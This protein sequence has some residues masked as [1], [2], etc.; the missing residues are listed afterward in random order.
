[1]PTG[2]EAGWAQCGFGRY[3]EDKILS[4][5]PESNVDFSVIQT[6]HNHYT[7]LVNRGGELNTGTVRALMHFGTTETN[8]PSKEPRTHTS[9]APKCVS[10]PCPMASLPLGS[11]HPGSVD[12]HSF[13]T[14][15]VSCTRDST[16]ADCIAEPRSGGMGCMEGAEGVTPSMYYS[17]LLAIL[18]HIS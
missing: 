14:Y 7:H 16:C 3:R 4:P 8:C 1:V 13:H 2:W 9:V 10:C 11:V 15:P 18:V 6:A 5:L 17:K 12:K